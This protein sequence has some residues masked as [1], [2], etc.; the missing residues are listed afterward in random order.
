MSSLVPNNTRL[1]VVQV[2]L[3]TNNYLVNLST[4]Y[5]V[6]QSEPIQKVLSI[7]NR[8]LVVSQVCDKY[9]SKSSLQLYN[10]S[11]NTVSGLYKHTYIIPIVWKYSRL[12]LLFTITYCHF[13]EKYECHSKLDDIARKVQ[14]CVNMVDKMNIIYFMN[15]NILYKWNLNEENSKS[16]ILTDFGLLPIYALYISYY[17]STFCNKITDYPSCSVFNVRRYKI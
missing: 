3:P 17:C 4:L 12:I 6:T 16:T 2:T 14:P 1:H 11:M 13:A 15:L 10:D 5:N 7:D 8:V 9:S